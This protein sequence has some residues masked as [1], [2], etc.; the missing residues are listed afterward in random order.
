[1]KVLVLLGQLKHSRV[2][3]AQAT[4]IAEELARGGELYKKEVYFNMFIRLPNFLLTFLPVWLL[5]KHIDDF[6]DV[7]DCDAI[8]VSGKKMI[9]Y[10]KHLRKFAFPNA[11]IVQIGNTHCPLAKTDILLKQATSKRVWPQKLKID[12]NGLICN[13]LDEKVALAETDRFKKIKSYL[14]GEFIGV[15][16]NGKSL[17]FDFL[18]DDVIAFAKTISRISYLMKMPLLIFS[19][20]NVNKLAV[21]LIKENLDCSYY[22]YDKRENPDENPKVA[23]MY[24]SSYY[25]LIGNS[26][27]DHSEYLSQGKPSYVFLCKNNTKK[28]KDF[29]NYAINNGSCVELNTE[30]DKLTY[31]EPKKLNDIKCIVGEIKKMVKQDV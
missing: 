29:I 5:V 16:I 23:F 31:Y 26:I 30:N 7:E 25:V 1:M 14:K 9:R 8:V 10:A 2:D 12:V 21:K 13:E 6:K 15:F 19:E 24:W 22:F 28:Y 20:K 3:N 11:R 18:Q 4:I 17:M 27:N